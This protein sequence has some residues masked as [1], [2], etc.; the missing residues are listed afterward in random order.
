MEQIQLIGNGHESAVRLGH[1]SKRG[2]RQLLAFRGH[3]F[4]QGLGD[5]RQLGI[6][7][8]LDVLAVVLGLLDH[9]GIIQIAQ[10]GLH[11]LQSPTLQITLQQGRRDTRVVGIVHI[12][13]NTHELHAP[14]LL[15]LIRAPPL[16][17]FSSF[18]NCSSDIVSMAFS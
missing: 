6:A 14:Y 1:D 18:S 9:L 15:R 10:V 3:T 11:V 5:G 13:I 17:F 12:V 4:I 2:F 7:E 8:E 16:T